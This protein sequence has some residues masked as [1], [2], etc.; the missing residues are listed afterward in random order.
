MDND[1]RLR[2]IEG[3]IDA[4]LGLVLMAFGFWCADRLAALFQRSFGWDRD[5][6]FFGSAITMYGVFI[7]W[8]GLIKERA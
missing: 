1:R 6:I 3:K 7:Y 8:Y 2:R 4:L 5:L